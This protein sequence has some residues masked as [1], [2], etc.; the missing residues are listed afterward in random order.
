MNYMTNRYPLGIEWIGIQPGEVVKWPSGVFRVVRKVSNSIH[1][2]PRGVWCYFSIRH[3]SWTGRC[4]TLYNVG[5][6]A[7]MR[8]VRTGVKVKFKH[9]LDFK[10]NRVIEAGTRELKCCDVRTVF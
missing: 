4:Y 10:V 3:C 7:Y 1:G 8:C 5:Q 6:L 2:N 9:R